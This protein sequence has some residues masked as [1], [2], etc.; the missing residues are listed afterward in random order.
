MFSIV[1][2]DYNLRNATIL[3]KFSDKRNALEYLEK[4]A[5]K[6]IAKQDG[7]QKVNDISKYL[8]NKNDL[9]L[10]GRTVGHYIVR[11]IEDHIDKLTIFKKE[12]LLDKGYIYNT[13]RVEIKK[14]FDIDLI[15]DESVT[16]PLFPHTWVD[17]MWHVF[18]DDFMNTKV[19]QVLQE[20]NNSGNFDK[21]V[22]SEL[23][24][25]CSND[26]NLISFDETEIKKTKK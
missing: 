4:Y 10:H 5:I 12:K 25:E 23:K 11:D 13:T 26:F 6:Y 24:K 15:Q 22:L 20:C 8:V 7:C 17:D 9:P 3:K 1:K 21:C 18:H 19:F 16:R 2:Y 14:V